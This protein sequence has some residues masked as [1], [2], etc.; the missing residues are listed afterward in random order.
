MSANVH[1]PMI[2]KGD[3]LPYIIHPIA[4]T[5][6]LFEWGADED[7]CIAGL[8]HDVLEDVPEEEK[9]QYREKIKERFGQSVLRIVEGVTEQDKSLTWKERKK[10]YL[11]HLKDASEQS[12]LISCADLTHNVAALTEA[13][14]ADGE[15][16]WERFNAGKEDKLWF[17]QERTRILGEKLDPQYSEELNHHLDTL[18]HLF[19][20]DS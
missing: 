8:L 13:Y 5:A 18:S 1:G 2:R 14:R 16:V 20:S 10:H 15:K 19:P 11:E 7:T 9:E 6:L 3:D 4:V 12:L 17:I